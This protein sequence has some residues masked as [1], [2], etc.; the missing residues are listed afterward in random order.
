MECDFIGSV[1]VTEID[2]KLCVICHCTK[3]CDKQDA[4]LCLVTRG[5]G[6]LIEYSVK[7]GDTVLTIH[8]LAE[9]PVVMVHNSCRKKL[10]Q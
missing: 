5:L 6:T 7:Y 10:R 2:I 1:S 4:D 3:H 9:P 8:L